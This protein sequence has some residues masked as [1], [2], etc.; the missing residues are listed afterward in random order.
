MASTRC[1]VHDLHTVA[2]GP[3]ERTCWRRFTAQ[4]GDCK[5]SQI[6]PLNAI[7]IIII[8]IIIVIIIMMLGDF[9]LNCKQKF[10]KLICLV[11]A[12]FLK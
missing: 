12:C 1:V 6:V 5:K 3:L 4:Y 9:F 2:P 11:F 8:I 7:I 10:D